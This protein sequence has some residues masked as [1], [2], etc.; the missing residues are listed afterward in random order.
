[1][2]DEVQRRAFGRRLRDL[3]LQKGMS[4][5]DLARLIWGTTITPQG[6]TVAKNRDRIAVYIAAKAWPS[7]V[8]MKKIADALGVEVADLAPG[9]GVEA[10]PPEWAFI[11]MEGQDKVLLR[12]NKLVAEQTALEIVRLIGGAPN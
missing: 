9:F 2:S 12:I 8:N 11:K 4:Q 1:M 3:L 7:P 10:G 5:S 6:H